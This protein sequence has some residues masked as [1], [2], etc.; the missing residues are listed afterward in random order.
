[1]SA[2]GVSFGA[3]FTTTLAGSLVASVAPE[4]VRRGFHNG[5]SAATRD[6]KQF[7]EGFGQ[8]TKPSPKQGSDGS[9]RMA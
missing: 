7:L 6:A 8:I 1:M 2:Y 5:A 3:T 9:R 4:S